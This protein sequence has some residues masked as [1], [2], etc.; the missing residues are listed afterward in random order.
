[1]MAGPD[2]PDPVTHVAGLCSVTTA[3][4]CQCRTQS[5]P[6]ALHD[7]RP[8]T[9]QLHYN[10]HLQNGTAYET[11]RQGVLAQR[12]PADSAADGEDVRGRVPQFPPSPQGHRA[13]RRWGLLPPGWRRILP[14]RSARI[15]CPPRAPTRFSAA[16]WRTISGP[17][18]GGRAQRAGRS[19]DPRRESALSRPTPPG[20]HRAPALAAHAD[21]IMVDSGPDPAG[22]H[23]RHSRKVSVPFGNAAC[24][25]QS[26]AETVIRLRAPASDANVKL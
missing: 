4:C 14:T 5:A 19:L 3:G 6:V 21:M 26:G 10:H 22:G 7:P 23:L 1:M 16:S 9:R 11:W 12:L 17:L 13:R 24:T 15:S 20:G 25:G 18:A 8:V 2:H